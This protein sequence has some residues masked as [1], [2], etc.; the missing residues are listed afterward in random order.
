MPQISAKSD[1]NGEAPSSFLSGPKQVAEGANF[2]HLTPTGYEYG[3]WAVGRPM[4]KTWGSGAVW[5][6]ICDCI[7][8]PDAAFGKT[9]G[10]PES[11]FAVDRKNGYE[12]RK[13]PFGDNEFD[14]GYWDPPYDKLYRPE[15]MEIWRVCRKVAILHTYCYPTSWMAGAKRTCGVAITMGPFKQIRFLQVFEKH[16]G[17]VA[18]PLRKR[19][20]KRL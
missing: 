9:D 14:F 6:R 4:T 3:F 17:A 2:M 10:I 5:K 20:S 16:N 8:V 7:G 18:P 13:L 1:V 19:T 15:C 11:V 12:W